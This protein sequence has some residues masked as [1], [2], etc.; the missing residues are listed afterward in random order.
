MK[1]QILPYDPLNPP[2]GDL[3][4]VQIRQDT[5]T[6]RLVLPLSASWRKDGRGR[7]NDYYKKV[8]RL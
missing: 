1:S 8:S 4:T 5:A 3:R 2:K 6:E 7:E